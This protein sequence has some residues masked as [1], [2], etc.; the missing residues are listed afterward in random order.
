[1]APFMIIDGNS[2]N[3]DAYAEEVIIKMNNIEKLKC[4]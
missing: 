1:M 3:P 4:K 2:S